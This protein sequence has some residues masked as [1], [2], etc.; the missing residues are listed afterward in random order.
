[1]DEFQN[2]SN[3]E[4]YTPLSEPLEFTSIIHLIIV[5]QIEVFIQRILR[6]VVKENI[7][8]IS[9]VLLSLYYFTILRNKTDVEV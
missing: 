5:F 1:M 3:P 7:E 4:C 6:M 9:Y 2:P 8:V